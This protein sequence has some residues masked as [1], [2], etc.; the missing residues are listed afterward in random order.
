MIF[1]TCLLTVLTQVT[2]G[3]L[4]GGRPP[5]SLAYLTVCSDCHI[6]SQ[7]TRLPRNALLNVR[8]SCP[9]NDSGG[10]SLAKHSFACLLPSTSL[11]HR[12]GLVSRLS[13][14]KPPHVVGS[15][16]GLVA[17]RAF[18]KIL[19]WHGAFLP[20]AEMKTNRPHILPFSLLHVCRL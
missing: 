20:L 5:P 9:R 3:Y 13:H 14:K 17:C 7:V 6:A 2:Y 18:P 8:Q 10:A 1:A 11:M 19:R 15:I 16:L 12:A 4:P